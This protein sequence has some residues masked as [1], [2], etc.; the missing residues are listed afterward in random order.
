MVRVKYCEKKIN[1]HAYKWCV[2][3]R[4]CVDV[5]KWFVCVCAYIYIYKWC[6]D[7][8][9][10]MRACVDVYKW[11]VCVHIYIYIYIYISGV[12]LSGWKHSPRGLSVMDI[13]LHTAHSCVTVAIPIT[14]ELT[15]T[16][17]LIC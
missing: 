4:A 11:F 9:V 8:C 5:Y 1:M 12:C 7:A 15:T 10:W 2:W 17:V 13:L 6:V 14:C 16:G 3:M